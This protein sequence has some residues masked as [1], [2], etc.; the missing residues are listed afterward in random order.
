MKDRRG[1]FANP[2][3]TSKAGVLEN[4]LVNTSVFVM[5]PPQKKKVSRP[6]KK[7]AGN[8]SRRRGAR[9]VSGGRTCSPPMKWTTGGY[10]GLHRGREELEPPRKR[11]RRNAKVRTGKSVGDVQCQL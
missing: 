9:F 6:K 8:P 7:T 2:P 5:S 10:S 11:E 4:V 3:L 1:D